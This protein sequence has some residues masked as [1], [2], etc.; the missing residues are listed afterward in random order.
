MEPREEPVFSVEMYTIAAEQTHISG[1]H[2]HPYHELYF[3]LDGSARHFIGNQIREV[4]AGEIAFIRQ[5]CIH[6]ATYDEGQTARRLLVSFSTE[7]VGEPYLFILRDLGHRKRIASTP[8]AV[9]ALQ[10]LFSSLQ[11]EYRCRQPHY[12]SQCRNLLRQILI[13]LSRQ[14]HT[15]P[16]WHISPNEEIIQNAAQYISEHYAE[17]LT[18]RELAQMF[19][20]SESHFS[21][22]FKEYTGVGVAQYIKHTRLRAAEK[23]L[24][25]E[26]CSVTDVA[27]S[28]GFTNSNYFISEF[29]KY[30]GITPLQ[31]ALA[32]RNE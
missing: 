27:F 6:K 29:K 24:L 26:G 2:S 12:L 13:L 4:K 18:L 28:C 11:E 5:G 3:L 10:R 8:E 15:E 1:E 19:A 9:V 7:F 31:Y 17:R 22:T 32:A 25:R 20:M 14:P 16:D 21:R 30:R 23:H